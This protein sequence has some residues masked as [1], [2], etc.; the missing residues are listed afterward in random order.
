MINNKDLI[1]SIKQRRET[2]K[3]KQRYELHDKVKQLRAEIVKNSFQSKPDMKL[4]KFLM[5]QLMKARNQIS[6][7]DIIK[8]ELA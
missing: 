3:S 2:F 1:T 5:S 7:N 6:F 8:K 4:H